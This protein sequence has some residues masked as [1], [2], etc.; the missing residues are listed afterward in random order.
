MMLSMEGLNC[1]VLV[2]SDLDPMEQVL[3][4]SEDRNTWKVNG[5]DADV[6]FFE[7][8]FLEVHTIC[9]DGIIVMPGKSFCKRTREEILILTQV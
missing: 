1:K 3:S 9:G 7:K 8:F 5:E 6:P 2:Y 4:V